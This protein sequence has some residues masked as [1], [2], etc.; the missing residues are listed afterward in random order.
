MHLIKPKGRKRKYDIRLRNHDGRTVKITGDRQ[1]DAA[2]RLGD[3]IQMLVNAKANG[4][5]PPAE[6]R[7]WIDNMPES[8]S[9]RLVELGLLDQ[10][11]L[12]R[13]KP[14]ADHIDSYE[15]VVAARKSN[16]VKHARQQAGKVR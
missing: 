14:L 11:R 16:T 5:L 4:D 15:K 13:L 6:L 8:L 9:S 10:Q 3:R 12:E 7:A 1:E 2:R